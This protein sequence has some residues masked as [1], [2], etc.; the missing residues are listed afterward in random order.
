VD[1]VDP[2]ELLSGGMFR[3]VS[4]RE[5]IQSFEWN[6]FQGKPVLIQGCPTPIPIWAYLLIMSKLI[7]YAKSISYGEVKSPITVHGTLGS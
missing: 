4:F 1:V 6:K 7:P 5:A 2:R 3:E